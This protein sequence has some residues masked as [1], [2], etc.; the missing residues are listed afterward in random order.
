M[1]FRRGNARKHG[2][3]HKLRHFRNLGND[4]EFG[5]SDDH[6]NARTLRNSG[7]VENT[8]TW[9]LSGSIINAGTVEISGKLRYL[10]AVE[11]ADTGTLVNSGIVRL[12]EGGSIEVADSIYFGNVEIVLHNAY[13]CATGTLVYTTS[14]ELRDAEAAGTVGED[15]I[16]SKTSIESYTTAISTLNANAAAY[17]TISLSAVA[18][19]E[20]IV[21]ELAA[22]GYFEYALA[23]QAWNLEIDISTFSTALLAA[24]QEINSGLYAVVD[25]SKET[26]I[27]SIY[28]VPEPSL[29]G[30]F[31]GISALALAVTRRR[32][33]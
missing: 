17:G 18:S 10:G 23:T 15:S 25:Y 29:F 14:D 21:K 30:V 32:K 3:D 20:A 7:T 4:H 33:K 11:Y 5:R 12:I 13:L 27:L 22:Q 8:G 16:T 28:V 6:G 19:D 31:A 1:G 26:G 2:N 9:T 24:L